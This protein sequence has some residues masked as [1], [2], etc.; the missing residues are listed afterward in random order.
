MTDSFWH[1]LSLATWGLLEDALRGALLPFLSTVAAAVAAIAAYKSVS[2]SRRVHRDNLALQRIGKLERE[3]DRLI[4]TP[5][6]NELSRLRSDTLTLIDQ[7]EEEI[8]KLAATDDRQMA[9]I[10]SARRL[11]R[12]YQQRFEE[13]RRAVASGI[14][15]WP[16]AD[17]CDALRRELEQLEDSVVREAKT[18]ADNPPIANVSKVLLDG[19]ASFLKTI[20]KYDPGLRELDS[21]MESGGK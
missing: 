10:S 17:C 7:A 12:G 19:I 8:E 2:E 18:L 14:G 3:Y 5:L 15:A 16:E 20:Y 1:L 6:M 9:I 13:L 21:L 4:S 11:V